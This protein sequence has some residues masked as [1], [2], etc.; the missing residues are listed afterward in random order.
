MEEEEEMDEDVVFLDET[1][2]M[3]ES[4]LLRDMEEREAIAS[5]L[6]KWKRPALSP[7]YQSYS[8]NIGNL[9]LTA[10]ISVQGHVEF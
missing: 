2:L 1:L 5:R 9:L 3:E 7:A 8:K 6:A 10:C 4:Q